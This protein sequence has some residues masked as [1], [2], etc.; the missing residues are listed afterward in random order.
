MTYELTNEE[1]MAIV[2]QH[3]KNLE[4]NKYNLKVSLIEKESVSSLQDKSFET[5]INQINDIDKQQAALKFELD[6]LSKEMVD[7]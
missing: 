1:K 2:N 3:L 6:T 7:Q 4:Y 5:L